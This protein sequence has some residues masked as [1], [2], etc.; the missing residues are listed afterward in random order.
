[1]IEVQQ[2]LGDTV[3]GQARLIEAMTGNHGA[4][5]MLSAI[6]HAQ[7]RSSGAFETDELL[8]V[9]REGDQVVFVLAHRN[10]EHVEVDPMPLSDPCAEAARR[11]LAR[12]SG[13]LV[14]LDYRGRK[15]V[16]AYEPIRAADVTWGLVAQVDLTEV[17]AP[18]WRAG[19]FGSL[20]ALG[21]VLLAA[22]LFAR[23][24]D[25]LV[26]RLE[27]SEQH[28]RALFDQSFQLLWTLKPDGTLLEANRTALDTAGV[29]ESA[30]CGR[31]F[32]DT[33]WWAGLLAEQPRL[34][35]AVGEA[36]AG[37]I[38]RMELEARGFG[39][40]MLTL[41]LSL[42]PVT[43]RKGQVVLLNA[44][45]RDITERKRA[46]KEIA[47]RTAFL[48]ALVEN[49]PL[50]IVSIDPEERVQQ[51]NSAFE[52]LFGYKLEEMKGK[53]IDEFVAPGELAAEALN[54]TRQAARGE[55]GHA[56]THRRRKDGSVFDVEVHSV[57]LVVGGEMVGG[58]AIYQ[59]I[60]ERRRAEAE[61]EKLL[62]ELQEA[63]ANLKTLS[64]LLPICASCKKI[65]DDQGYWSQI[66]S[67]VSAHSQAQFSHGICPECAK[68]LYPEHYTKMFPE[69]VEQE[70]EEK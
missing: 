3:V 11:A 1:L 61:R 13:A 9:S 24:S 12:E 42:K 30:V 40:R 62:R 33:R 49:S 44:E 58:Y 10:G 31:S 50:A 32:W 17:Q 38:A 57:P 26:Q 68:Q 52:R 65:R 55:I 43:N 64:G 29:I 5:T 16:A 66:E 2:R 19:V 46:E 8:L 14:G 63:L 4:A 22:V 47:Q 51:C 36:A 69:L 21:L 6:E 18:F 35:W 54:L 53:P 34:E 23:F 25:P 27:E 67:Y 7:E 41:D 15:V 70:P 60:T 59:D 37:N 56:I 28:H 45:A 39:Q 48:N 20:L